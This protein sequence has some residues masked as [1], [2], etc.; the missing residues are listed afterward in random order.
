MLKHLPDLLFAIMA[1]VIS[2]IILYFI[3]KWLDRNNK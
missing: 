3:S 2:G 1:N